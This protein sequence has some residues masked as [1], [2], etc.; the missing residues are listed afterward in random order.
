MASH[1]QLALRPTPPTAVSV[2]TS[3]LR[4]EAAATL[5]KFGSPGS[6]GRNVY[7]IRSSKDR[8][9]QTAVSRA[10]DPD[11]CSVPASQ[12]RARSG[13]SSG[14]PVATP[15]AKTS[16]NVGSLIPRPAEA[17][18]RVPAASGSANPA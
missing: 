15:L 3:I 4:A 9:N 17:V 8:S 5:K 1:V 7:W 13:S 14:F 6:R 2:S 12:A 11:A 16:K 18:S 10:I